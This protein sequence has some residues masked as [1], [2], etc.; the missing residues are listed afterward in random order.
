MDACAECCTPRLAGLL[1]ITQAR[2]GAA[3][4]KSISLSQ[5]ERYGYDLTN[6]MGT[7][8]REKFNFI[9]LVIKTKQRIFL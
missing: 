3:A 4:E 8:L 7:I 9:V 1:L 2:E 5:I 6:V